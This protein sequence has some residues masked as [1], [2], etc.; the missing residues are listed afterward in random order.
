MNMYFSV[1]KLQVQTMEGKMLLHSTEFELDRGKVVGVYGPNGSG[2]TSLLRALAGVNRNFQVG[3]VWV[4]QMQITAAQKPEHRVQKILYLGSDYPSPFEIKVRDLMD[5]GYEFSDH[6]QNVEE[7]TTELGIKTLNSRIV[8]TLSDGEKQWVMFARALIQNPQ[9]LVLDESFSK[10][11]LDRLLHAARIIRKQS[12][13]GMTMVAA[14]HDL[15]F[16]SEISDRL[17]FMQNGRVLHQGEVK[18]VMNP[19]FL[20]KLYPD[21]QLQVVKSPNSGKEKIIY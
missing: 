3:E 16:I 19:F 4:D 15:N 12:E 1:R 5:L 6:P 7:I 11:D 9:V 2:K 20:E 17:I 14:S 13:R 8:S 18:E 21:L 10:L